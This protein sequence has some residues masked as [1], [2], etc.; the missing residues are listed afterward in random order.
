MIMTDDIKK[1]Y[2]ELL[3]SGLTAVAAAQEL[4][5]NVATFY[6][7]RNDDEAFDKACKEAQLHGARNRLQMLESEAYRRAV[8][9]VDEPV[10]YKG[11][12]CGA[13]RKYSDKILLVLL[14]AE[15][16]RAGDP[17]Y[18]DRFDVTSKDDKV[19]AGIIVLGKPGTDEDAW[20]AEH[21]K[22]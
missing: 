3:E 13:V 8:E 4:G 16:N 12:E 19:Q 9:G 1:K 17:A 14:K 11:D 7:H 21:S 18:K 22:P 5:P 15:A 20:H 2:I 6:R 10:F